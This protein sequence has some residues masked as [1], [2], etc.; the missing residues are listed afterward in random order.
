MHERVP[1]S[2]QIQA[3]PPGELGGTERQMAFLLRLLSDAPGQKITRGKLGRRIKTVGAATAGLRPTNLSALI[4]QLSGNGF[5]RVGKAGRADVYELTGAGAAH[6]DEVRD[7][8]SLGGNRG[9]RGR[10]IPPAND[11][12]RNLRLSYLLLQSLK[13]HPQPLP[14]AEANGLLDSYAR[15]GLELNS[16]TASHLRQELV[17]Q[18]LFARTGSGRAIAYTLTP[19]GRLAVGNSAFPDDRK[20]PLTGRVLNQLLEM[21]REVGKQFTP[22]PE[23]PVPPPKAEEIERAILAA[24]EEMLRER[25]HVTGLVPIHEVRDAVRHRF[26]EVAARHDVFD[27][28]L[29]RLRLT[30]GLRLVPISN[31]RDATPEQLRA[32]V[33]GMGETIFYLEAAR[34]PAAC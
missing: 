31:P 26:G 25:H 32:S 5:V 18:G 21:A 10:V 19:A 30:G 1:T 34:E 33:P 7:R 13:T 20:F 28:V 15:D 17:R 29:L 12:V 6:L 9:G 24:F 27:P 11:Q 23:L 3:I 14:E 8:F 16:A 4:T 22:D 2:P